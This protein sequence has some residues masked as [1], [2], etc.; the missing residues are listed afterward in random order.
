MWSL[1][2]IFA[3]LLWCNE[4]QQR[5]QNI[6]KLSY[7]FPGTSCFPLSPKKGDDEKS[8]ESIELSSKDQLKVIFRTL[9]TPSDLDKS[10]ISTENTRDYLESICEHKHKNKLDK[11]FPNANPEAMILLKGLLEINPHFRLSAKEALMSPLFDQIRQCHFER[12]CPI[13]VNQKIHAEGVYD[14]VNFEDVTFSVQ[15]YKKMLMSEQKKIR[16]N[17]CL[18]VNKSK[19]YE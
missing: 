18:Y 4:Y 13:R 6:N 11:V 10:F 3:E 7:L 9:G 17:S 12:P 5:N 16:K 14:Y 15:D 19:N 1:G 8:Y 2:C